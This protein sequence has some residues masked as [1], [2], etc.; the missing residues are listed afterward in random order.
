MTLKVSSPADLSPVEPQ[1][2]E[3]PHLHN[4]KRLVFLIRQ[5]N[6]ADVG[7]A[8]S[9]P[10][11]MAPDAEGNRKLERA[12][13]DSAARQI[14]EI[15]RAGIVEPKLA[16]TAEEP[17]PRWDHLS[18]GNQ[19][20]VVDAINR[21]AGVSQSVD[22]GAAKRTAGFPDERRGKKDGADAAPPVRAA[23]AAA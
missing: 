5:L 21:M 17:G 20:A 11:M 9:A 15:A 18:A 7:V 1:L 22:L 3:L 2:F 16:F 8:Q 14:R 19:M 12:E 13:A 10:P 4:G 23:A 6:L